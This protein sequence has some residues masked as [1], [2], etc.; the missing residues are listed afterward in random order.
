MFVIKPT[1]GAVEVVELEQSEG[2]VFVRI[3]GLV[4]VSCLEEG[5]VIQINQKWLVERGYRVDIVS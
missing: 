3:D 2:N 4:G 5:R 1:N